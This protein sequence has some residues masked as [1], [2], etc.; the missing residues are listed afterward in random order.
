MLALP[1]VAAAVALFVLYHQPAFN[2]PSWLPFFRHEAYVVQAEFTTAQAVVPGQGQAVTIA[3][4]PV[5]HVTAVA[6]E[7]GHAVVRMSLDRGRAEVFRDARIVLRP[8]TPLKDMFLALDPG[9]RAAGAVPSGG[10]LSISH[11]QPDVNVDEF[12]SAFDADTRDYLVLLLQAAGTALGSDE[13]GRP[14]PRQVASLRATLKRFAPLSRD[15]RRL[16]AALQSRRVALRTVV[17]SYGQVAHELGGLERVVTAWVIA[18]NGS[19]EVLAQRDGKLRDALTEFPGALGALRRALR[20][21]VGLSKATESATR[22]LDPFARAYRPSLVASERLAVD[23]TGVLRDG[24]RPAVRAARTPVRALGLGTAALARTGPPL[25]RSFDVLADLFRG[26][27]YNPPGGEEGYLFWS[28]WGAH[29]AQSVAGLQDANG[30]TLRTLPLLTCPQLDAVA[31][32]EAGNETVGALIRLSN[33]P[34]RLKL[35]AGSTPL[36]GRAP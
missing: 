36:P 24:L 27:G 33:L 25:R 14:A 20:S 21:S 16:N 6:L 5:G 30:P 18:S 1:V 35:C 26:L 3:G 15:S 8:R 31:Q 7:H 13:R 10:R 17:H 28:A 29:I 4:V 11:T 32:I 22:R 2:A 12:L 34:D 9:T 23:T 19:L